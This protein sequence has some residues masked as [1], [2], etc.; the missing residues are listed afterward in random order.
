MKPQYFFVLLFSCMGVSFTGCTQE[1]EDVAPL[2]YVSLHFPGISKLSSIQVASQ[3]A[4]QED[5]FVPLLSK[6]FFLGARRCPIP[7]SLQMIKGSVEI[8]SRPRFCKTTFKT[9][10]ANLAQCLRRLFPCDE[11]RRIFQEKAITEKQGMQLF[12]R[13]QLRAG[14]QSHAL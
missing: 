5:L 6:F 1:K 14:Q 7:K 11:A 9:K 4:A 3:P 2:H 10:D 8:T 12:L 13:A